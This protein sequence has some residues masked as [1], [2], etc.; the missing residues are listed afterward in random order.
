[1]KR[2]STASESASGMTKRC[3]PR[4]DPRSGRSSGSGKGF[5]ASGRDPR[6]A[7]RMCDGRIEAVL[8][9]PFLRS[10]GTASG[11]MGFLWK[12]TKQAPCQF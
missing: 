4:R 6:R 7:N 1:M 9:P 2:Q 11:A 10:F 5:E 12:W 3:A 8:L